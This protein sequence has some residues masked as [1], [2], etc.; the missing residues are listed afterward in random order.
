MTQREST[1]GREKTK[2]KSGRE[3]VKSGRENEEGEEREDMA[4]S[5]KDPQINGKICQYQQ[6]C[7]PKQDA[8]TQGT[9][10]WALSS[11]EKI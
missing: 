6:S 2:Q 9:V 4:V 10:V 8:V 3:N 11:L 5:Q 1:K 7:E